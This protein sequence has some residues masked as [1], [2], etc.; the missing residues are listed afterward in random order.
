MHVSQEDKTIKFLFFSQ[1][2]RYVPQL[3]VAVLSDGDERDV[4]DP[5]NFDDLA[6]RV[7]VFDLVVL[8]RLVHVPDHDGRVEAARGDPARV[9]A[10]GD[11]VD[12]AGVEAP[13]VLV[14]QLKAEKKKDVEVGDGSGAKG[15]QV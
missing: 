7:G 1:I 4:V 9:R 11:A 5:G 12:S 3:G 2:S 13:V 8:V 14:S 6:H 15:G 10:P